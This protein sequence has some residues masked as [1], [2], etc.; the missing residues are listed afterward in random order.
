MSVKQVLQLESETVTGQPIK[1]PFNFTNKSS[2]PKGKTVGDSI[3]ITPITVRT[4]FRLKHFLGMIEVQDID[5]LS[6][7]DGT[8]LD[9]EK[10]ALMEKY[11]KL[12]FEIVCIG[13]HN[14]KGDMPKWFREVLL[15]NCTWQDI[16]ILLNSILFRIGCNPFINSITLIKN[17]SPLDE[18]GIIAL[19]K[20]KKTWDRKAASCSSPSAR[21]R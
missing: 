16:Y 13:I 7:K 20:N 17:V 9:S 11:D 6:S 10:E 2:V 12:L 15:D 4:W 1:I 19:Q 18:R 5:K 14:K 3:V 8:A 21:K